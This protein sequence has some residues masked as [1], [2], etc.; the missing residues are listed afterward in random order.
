MIKASSLVAVLTLATASANAGCWVV[1]NVSGVGSQQYNEY[2]FKQ[3]GFSGKVFVLNFDEESPYVTDSLMTYTVL[4]PTSMIGI[5][6]IGLGKTI[7]TWQIST[8]GTKAFMTLSRTNSN[9][10]SQDSVG[11]FVGDV[12]AKCDPK[13]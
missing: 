12:K 5:Y 7:Q 10:V 13:K 2:K 8:D 6:D 1:G 11:S 9:K 4:S 3:D